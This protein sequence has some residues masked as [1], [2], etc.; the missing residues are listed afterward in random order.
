MPVSAPSPSLFFVLLGCGNRRSRSSAGC[1][2]GGTVFLH[3]LPL[4]CLLCR[5]VVLRVLGFRGRTG[6][7]VRCCLCSC[8]SCF[9]LV[10]CSPCC[11]CCLSRAVVSLSSRGHCRSSAFCMGGVTSP[12]AIP[13]CRCNRLPEQNASGT[14]RFVVGSCVVRGVFVVGAGMCCALWFVFFVVLCVCVWWCVDCQ[15]ARVV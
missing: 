11:Q 12:D 1:G 2:R 10:S 4:S 6:L 15:F 9:V 5:P 14:T 3:L 7:V 13:A 8:S